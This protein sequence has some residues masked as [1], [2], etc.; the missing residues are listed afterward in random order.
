MYFFAGKVPNKLLSLTA[1]ICQKLYSILSVIHNAITMTR[2]DTFS[3]YGYNTE[4][5][6]S[7]LR[8]NYKYRDENKHLII[9]I[10]YFRQKRM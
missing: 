1:I 4:Y 2:F 6:Y 7:K 10:K 8:V 3:I 9:A 5:K